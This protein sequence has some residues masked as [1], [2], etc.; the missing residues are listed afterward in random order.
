[1]SPKDKPLPL[2]SQPNALPDHIDPEQHVIAT[3][4][5]GAP[6][7][8]PIQAICEGAAVEQSTGTWI[9]VPGETPQMRK[10]HVAKVM[11]IYEGPYPEYSQPR[12]VTHRH[13]IVQVAYPWVNFGQQI[14]MLLSTVV[15]NISMGGRVKVLDLRFPKSWLKAFQGP[16]FG[17]DGV[18]KALSLK[19]RRP[20]LNNMI[21]PCTGYSPETGAELLYQAARGGADVVKDDELIADPVFNR[22]TER[23]PLYMEAIDKANAEKGEKTLYTV[24]I[25]DRI[26]KLMENAE[27]AIEHGAN[28]LMINYLAVGYSATRQVCEDPSINVP[29]LGHMDIAGALSY[30]PIVGLASSLVMGK[31]PRISGIDIGVYPAPYGKAPLLK[32]RYME[33]ARAMAYPL[34]HLKPTM[35]MPSGGITPGHV[36]MVVED[37][38]VDIMIGTGGGIHAYPAE[39]GGPP[40][41]ARAFRQAIDATVKGIP[42]KEFAQDHKELKVALDQWGSGKTGFDM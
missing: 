39:H 12:D 31:L 34:Q 2:E 42:L 24:N 20:L 13:Y 16:K 23:L 40:A 8:F 3:Y 29:V 11:G 27:A 9:L 18:Y 17:I 19:K 25:T 33:M 6:L 5:F 37:L 22:I 30:S 38:G 36:P 15:G 1:M 14:P 32:Q 21:K 7:G 26:P 35:P 41:G 10:K 28:A 4:Y